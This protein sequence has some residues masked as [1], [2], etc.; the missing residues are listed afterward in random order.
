MITPKLKTN[1]LDSNQNFRDGCGD[2][3]QRAWGLSFGFNSEA[4]ALF[5]VGGGNGD[6]HDK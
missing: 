3:R 1:L 2:G 5:G 4:A 6:T